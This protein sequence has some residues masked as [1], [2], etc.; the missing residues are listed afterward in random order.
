MTTTTTTA[1][2]NATP[3][4]RTTEARTAFLASLHS[5]G[6]Q[7]DAELHAR[8]QDIHTSAAALARQDA[9]VAA[10][11]AALAQQTAGYR[12]LADESRGT[13]K[14]IGDVQ[15]WAEMIERDLLVL[16]ETM[17]VVEEEGEGQGR[18]GKGEGRGR[19]WF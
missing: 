11:T 2:P 10:Q 15:N 6:S 14:E 1:T 12:Q 3:T 19:R 17:R 4:Q 16:E 7:S 8:A 5:V 9:G 13:L 18:R